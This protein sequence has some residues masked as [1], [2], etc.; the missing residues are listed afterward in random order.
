MWTSCR[1]SVAPEPRFPEQMTPRQLQDTFQRRLLERGLQS[2]T[3]GGT[4]CKGPV[5]TQARRVLKTSG[6]C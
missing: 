5:V 3:F 1:H 2:H 6:G 4:L